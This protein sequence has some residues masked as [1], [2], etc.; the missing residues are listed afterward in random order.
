M[1]HKFG[2]ARGRAFVDK[3]GV[4]LIRTAEVTIERLSIALDSYRTPESPVIEDNVDG[5]IVQGIEM[6][7]FGYTHVPSWRVPA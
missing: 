7:I 1:L 6:H 5:V 2:E 3:V 4:T